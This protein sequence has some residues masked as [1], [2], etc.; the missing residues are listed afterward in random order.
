MPAPRVGGG[1]QRVE[2]HVGEN[3]R[4]ALSAMKADVRSQMTVVRDRA[5]EPDPVVV[6]PQV[7][8]RGVGTP[9]EDAREQ[10]TQPARKPQLTSNTNVEG[11]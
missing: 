4:A 1:V 2:R 9:V 11:R 8:D 7:V 10:S 6:L 3:G 5:I